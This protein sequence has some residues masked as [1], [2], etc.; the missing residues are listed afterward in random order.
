MQNE[1]GNDRTASKSLGL[2]HPSVGNN[3]GVQSKKRARFG[4]DLRADLKVDLAD[5]KPLYFDIPLFAAFDVDFTRS[6]KILLSELR[7][8]AASSGKL[9]LSLC[10]RKRPSERANGH[11]HLLLPDILPHAVP[12]SC[13][14]LELCWANI[15][16]ILA[17][18]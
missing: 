13:W 14:I 15:C 16:R 18:G 3:R 11:W 4:A 8:G 5:P 2:R 10:C 6:G 17:Y 1:K 7:H 9:K 12:P